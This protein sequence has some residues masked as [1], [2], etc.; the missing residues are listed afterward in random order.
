[1][2]YAVTAILI[3]SVCAVVASIATSAKCRQQVAALPPRYGV[4]LA[5]GTALI[6]GCFFA[7]RSECYR[8]IN[9]LLTLPGL[10]LLDH[11]DGPRH[12]RRISEF[13]I[14]AI[15]VVMFRLPV[16]GVLSKY[17][18]LPKSSATGAIAWIGF[19]LLWW[20]IVAVLLALLACFLYESTARR[21]IRALFGGSSH[22]FELRRGLG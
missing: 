19:E 15:L 6:V 20:W 7:G 5:I 9:L 17:A 22:R 4:L 13:T 21:E 8:D 11:R 1:L 3:A 2:I 14:A 16:I 18:L 12:L 10:A